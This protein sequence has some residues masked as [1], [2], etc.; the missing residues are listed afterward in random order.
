MASKNCQ[1]L[2]CLHSVLQA[3]A[4]LPAERDAFH[5]IVTRCINVSIEPRQT[6]G[7]HLLPSAVLEEAGQI[8]DVS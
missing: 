3:D 7:V 5:D 6:R 2:Q 8:A 4:M 1:H